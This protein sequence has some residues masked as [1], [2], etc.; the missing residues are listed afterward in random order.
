MSASRKKR[1]LRRCAWGRSNSPALSRPKLRRDQI[2]G[3]RMGLVRVDRVASMAC[4]GMGLM[5][6]VPGPSVKG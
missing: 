6:Q 1:L 2:A 4:F 3:R 5:V